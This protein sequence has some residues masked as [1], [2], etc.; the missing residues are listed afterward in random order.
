MKKRLLPTILALCMMTMMLPISVLATEEMPEADGQ[1]IESSEVEDSGEDTSVSEDS[2]EDTTEDQTLPAETSEPASLADDKPVSG[3][4][5]ENVTWTL[6]GDGLLT[7]S[8]IGAITDFKFYNGSSSPFYSMRRDIRTVIIQ[9]GV[10]YIG[11]ATFWQCYCLTKITIPSSV[12][13]IGDCAFYACSSLTNISLPD[14]I[15]SIG[16]NAF[17]NCSQLTSMII[18]KNV[19]SIG[20]TAFMEC[21]NL[22]EITV[23]TENTTYASEDG[24][25]FNKEKTELIVCPEKKKGKEGKYKIPNTVTNIKDCAFVSCVELSDIEIPDNVKTI[26]KS[27]FAS[28]RSLTD[29]VIPNSVM[30]IG[31]SAF[32][33]CTSLVSVVFSDN[34]T[35]IERGTFDSCEKLRCVYKIG[36]AHV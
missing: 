12:T 8:G 13:R 4:C 5:G 24:V 32:Y 9:E 20:D 18:P 10:T 7:I 19:V 6:N 30:S 27:A 21:S 16:F 36:R 34:I 35:E 23:E 28:C 3:T 1:A 25:L 17:Y 33:R 29:A 22:K 31:E 2:T 15:T 26:G 11:D 14:S